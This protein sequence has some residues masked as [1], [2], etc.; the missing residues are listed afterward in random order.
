MPRVG[1]GSV[2]DNHCTQGL[3]GFAL[4]LLSFRGKHGI[5]I[6]FGVGQQYDSLTILRSRKNPR[7]ITL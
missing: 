4:Q 5:G 7:D 3:S 2:P 6:A 1:V